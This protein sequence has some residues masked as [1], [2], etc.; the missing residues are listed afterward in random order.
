[1]RDQ[2]ERAAGRDGA[3]RPADDRRPFGRAHLEIEDDHEPERRGLWRVVEEIRDDPVHID[4]ASADERRR[5]L[6]SDP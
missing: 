2:Q 4:G 5:L 3:S 1:V 6:D